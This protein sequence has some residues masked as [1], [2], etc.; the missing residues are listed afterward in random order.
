MKHFVVL[1]SLVLITLTG[2]EEKPQKV[3]D[4]S[5]EPGPKITS[6]EMVTSKGTMVIELSNETPKHRDNFIKLANEMAFDS[7]LFH[8][9]IEAFMIQ[10]GDPDS[11]NA[12]PGD[13]LG[14]GDLDYMVDAEFNPKLFHK[15]GALS[16]ARDGN[17]E[18]ASSAM[19][20]F[21]VQG[22]AF[23]DSTLTKAETR[24]NGWLAEHHV[25]HLPE[26]KAL[27]DSLRAAEKANDMD[28]YYILSDSVKAIAETFDDFER[29]AIPEEHREV[30]RT[31]GGTP[32]LDQ[33]YTVFGQVV[34]GLAVVDSIAAVQTDDMDRPLE[35]VRVLSVRVK[36]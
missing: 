20:F 29:Y 23:D 6:V 25:K 14:E 32:H 16:A 13:T 31:L 12:M 11:K 10:G 2:C 34:E 7:L 18:R 36:K 26:H 4:P 9:V 8:R 28:R 30:Y 15:K 27:A 35:D 3:A 1:F 19:Q 24:I 5:P 17:L 33:N 21:I 22:K